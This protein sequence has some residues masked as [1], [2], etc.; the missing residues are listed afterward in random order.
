MLDNS[1][2]QPRGHNAYFSDSDGHILTRNDILAYQHKERWT[3]KTK[4]NI[5]M[6]MDYKMISTDEVIERFRSSLQEI[7][8]WRREVSEYRNPDQST[9]AL[10]IEKRGSCGSY[11]Q[12]VG[13]LRD[14]ITR[15]QVTKSEIDEEILRAGQSRILSPRAQE[16]LAAAYHEGMLDHN[17]LKRMGQMQP[18]DIGGVISFPLGCDLKL[19]PAP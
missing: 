15:G 4:Q 6:A 18:D 17:S 19:R 11:V 9:V 2:K 14:L 1:K 13:L 8:F 10:R 5:L 7:E 16:M 3:L 12:K